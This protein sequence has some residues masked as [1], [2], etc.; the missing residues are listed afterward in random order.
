MA[1]LI[2][3]AAL[4]LAVFSA[5]PA[6]ARNG[7]EADRMS[8]SGATPAIAHWR[9]IIAEASRRFAIPEVWITAVMRVESG[10]HVRL[11]GRAITSRAGAMGLMQIMPATWNAM[12]TRLGLG[13]DPYDPHDNILAGAAYLRL[14]HE[15]YGYPGL[16]AAYNAGPGRYDA[17][18]HGAVPLPGETRAYIASLARLPAQ[19]AMPSAILSGTHLFFP[20][21]VVRAGDDA[22]PPDPVDRP[23]NLL[24]VPLARPPSKP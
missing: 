1:A 13:A 23:R 2:R 22:P 18:L 12:R 8:V 19:A 4:I 6:T 11:N 9:P 17:Y 14:M 24:F 15:R 21:G 10:G 3:T 7:M 5:T 16:F 20:L